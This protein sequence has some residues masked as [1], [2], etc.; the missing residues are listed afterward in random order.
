[1]VINQ[2]KSIASHIG[3]FEFAKR[4]YVRGQN[5]SP[6]SFRR[7][8]LMCKTTRGLLGIADKY[9]ISHFAVL[10][11]V[12]GHG[13][14]ALGRLYHKRSKKLE[15]LWIGYSRPRHGDPLLWDLWLGRGSLPQAPYLKGVIVD[16]LRRKLYYRDLTVPPDELVFDGE[17]EI[18]E[19]TCLRNWMTQWLTWV[20]WYHMVAMA[21]DPCLRDLLFDCPVV[22][23]KWYRRNV[24]HELVTFGR[25]WKVYDMIT[26]LGPDWHPGILESFEIPFS[27]WILGGASGSDFMMAP[28]AG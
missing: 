4:F 20:K 2:S 25:L 7:K 3:G 11:R 15:R 28:E 9:S 21:P 16:F 6:V 10:A 17:L 19:R 12:G 5:L 24:D 1:M 27:G 13:Y 14:K 18:L 8:R 23:T 26:E 22:E